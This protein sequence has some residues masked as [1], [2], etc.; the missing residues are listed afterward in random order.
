MYV[1]GNAIAYGADSRNHRSEDDDQGSES[2]ELGSD[3]FVPEFQRVKSVLT[4]FEP[5]L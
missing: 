4:G 3:R 2:I 5:R 1:T